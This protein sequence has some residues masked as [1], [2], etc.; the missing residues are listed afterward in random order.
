ML[1]VADFGV[2]DLYSVNF[3]A[4]GSNRSAPVGED[5]QIMPR[6]S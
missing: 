2:G 6:P 3:S 4:V 1:P 5:T